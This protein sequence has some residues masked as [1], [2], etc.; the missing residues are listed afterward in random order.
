ML[1]NE[2]RSECF[3][4]NIKI[5]RKHIGFTQKELATHL[6]TFSER[7][8]FHQ[9]EISKYEIFG[10]VPSISKL[11]LIKNAFPYYFDSI[12]DIYS[13]KLT[14]QITQIKESHEN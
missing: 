8:N 13:K 12:E 1:T 5:I 11:T 2:E 7:Y 3:K 6:S 10:S 4:N 9:K 14:T